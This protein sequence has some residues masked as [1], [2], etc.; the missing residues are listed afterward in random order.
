MP[1]EATKTPDAATI[2][3]E[4]LARKLDASVAVPGKPRDDGKKPAAV[5]RKATAADIL[6]FTVRDGVA[7]VVTVDG[8]RHEVKL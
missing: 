3:K 6:D 1:P 8:R 4:Q 5:T 2:T 7:S